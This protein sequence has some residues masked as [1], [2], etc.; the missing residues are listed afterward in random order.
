MSTSTGVDQFRWNWGGGGGGDLCNFYLPC[1]HKKLLSDQIDTINFKVLHSCS[2]SVGQ[3]KQQQQQQTSTRKS[4][5]GPN[6]STA[7]PKIKWFCQTVI[8]FSPNMHGHLNSSRGPQPPP[9]P[10]PVRLCLSTILQ[11]LQRRHIYCVF[12]IICFLFSFHKMSSISL[13]CR[14]RARNGR[15]F[16]K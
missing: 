6:I 10:P 8:I 15:H 2:A 3:A 5:F 12:N 16:M 4:G 9:P 11:C 13:H 1:P 7:Y 14:A